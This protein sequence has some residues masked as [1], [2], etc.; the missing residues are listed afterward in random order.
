[1]KLLYRYFPLDQNGK[2]Q[3]PYLKNMLLNN[4]YYFQK[5]SNFNDPFDCKAKFQINLKQNEYNTIYNQIR[6]G[7]PYSGHVGTTRTIEEIKSNPKLLKKI[8]DVLE[9]QLGIN[10]DK[11]G[12]MCLSKE[13]TNLLMWSHYSNGH[14]GYCIGLNSKKLMLYSNQNGPYCR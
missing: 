13:L 9:I 7:N 1:M 12:I 14:K 2:D 4:Q 8:I 11:C 3:F 10:L 5:P 6:K